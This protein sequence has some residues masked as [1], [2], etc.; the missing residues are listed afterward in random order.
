MKIPHKGMRRMVIGFKHRPET[1]V[2]TTPQRIFLGM[3]FKGNPSDANPFLKMEN[4]E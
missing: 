4:G 3:R 2:K 1:P